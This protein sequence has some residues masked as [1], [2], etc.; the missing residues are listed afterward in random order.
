MYKLFIGISWIQLTV[1]IP[2]F[3]FMTET[4]RHAERNIKNRVVGVWPLPW[5]GVTKVFQNPPKGTHQM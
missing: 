5:G 2:H 1:S 3:L 4:D